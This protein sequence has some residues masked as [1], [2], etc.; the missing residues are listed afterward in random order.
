VINSI[1]SAGISG[2]G[3]LVI[4]SLT[5]A[6]TLDIGTNDLDL[7][8]ND[9]ASTTALVASGF[10][11]GTFDGSGITSSAAAS[12][13]SHLHT[14][15]VISNNVSNAALYGSASPMGLFDGADPGLND[16]L[17]KYTYYGDA[18]LDGV[19][20]G[21]DY[22]LIDNGYINHLT[23]WYNGD[24]NYDGVVNGTDYTLIDNAFNRQGAAQNASGDALLA[25]ATAQ[26]AATTAVPEPA[27]TALL[28]LGATGLLG[29]RRGR[30]A[31]RKQTKIEDRTSRSSILSTN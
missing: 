25:S 11:G 21:S 4:P 26:L 16:V 23:G 29:R 22:S 14:V 15:G 5:V 12:D 27:T 3:V 24:F 31:N 20:D 1:N 8:S 30:N 6:G 18:N 19:V 28:V 9:L 2:R 13:T 10:N 7:T 17:V